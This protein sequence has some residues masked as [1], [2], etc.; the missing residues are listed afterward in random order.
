[1]RMFNLIDIGERTGSGIPNI[2]RV[3]QAQGWAAPTIT[4]SFDP[5]RITLTL[6]LQ[7]PD[8]PA[9]SVKLSDSKAIISEKMKESIIV[10]LTDHIAAS[11]TTIAAYLGLKPSRTYD[12]LSELVADD[13]VVV[14]GSSRHRIYRLKS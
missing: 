6:Q 8:A 14:E 5:E 10:Y 4:E 9:G 12:Y 2:F 1:M 3:W 7:A 13:I 11:V